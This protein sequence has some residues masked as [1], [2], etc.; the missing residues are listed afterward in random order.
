MADPA[1]VPSNVVRI[2]RGLKHFDNKGIEQIAYYQRGV[3]TDSDLE[4]KVVGG[5]T[6][7]DV[8]E[9][10]REAYAMIANNFNPETQKELDSETGPV[11]Q[12]VI[13]GFSRGA[14]TARAIASL[15]S[16]IG[17]LTKVGMESFWGI[18]DDWKNQD[19][20][21]HKSQ[22]FQNKFPSVGNVS[23]ADPKYRQALMDVS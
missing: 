4:D 14:F 5:L 13:L 23:F 10:V 15:I 1:Q 19:I 2:V 21:G 9:H 17:L 8:G 6:G 22:W 7:S 3:G 16:D 12:I 18:F 11:D 20:M